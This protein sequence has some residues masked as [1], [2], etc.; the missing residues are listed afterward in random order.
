MNVARFNLAHGNH[1]IHAQYISNVRTVS[2]RLG[3]KVAIL[4][5]LPGPKYRIG[6][7]REGQAVLKKG[8]RLTLTSRDTDGDA[9]MLPVEGA[10][11]AFV[12]TR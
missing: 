8:S 6:R 9:I 4:I 1:D 7:L 11:L 12:A 5:D 10:V 3:M 2:Q